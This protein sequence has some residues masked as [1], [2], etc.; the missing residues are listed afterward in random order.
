MKADEPHE[1]P[2][3]FA[4]RDLLKRLH[5]SKPSGTE[6]VFFSP[7]TPTKMISENTMSKVLKKFYPDATVHGMRSAYRDWAEIFTD[8]SREVKEAVLAHGNPDKVES[9]YLRTKY[10]DEREDL[11][12]VWGLWATGTGGTYQ[13][14]LKQY[15][16]DRT[17]PMEP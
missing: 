7:K 5:S 4:A 1:V 12:E 15:R 10:L 17:A 11:M 13:Q 6:L 8:A 9:A 16:R 14:L 2:L 3:P